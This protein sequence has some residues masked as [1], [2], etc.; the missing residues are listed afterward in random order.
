[1]HGSS[2][3]TQTFGVQRLIHL[4]VHR[5]QRSCN[6]SDFL[7]T[8]GGLS[9]T[10]WTNDDGTT[11]SSS[12][13][14]SGSQQTSTFWVWRKFTVDLVICR[15]SSVYLHFMLVGVTYFRSDFALDG[16]KV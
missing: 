16:I 3:Q 1:M 2:N 8:G 12:N 10:F 7:N 9:M 5:Q 15:E 6:S 13:R 4:Q 14:I 11:T